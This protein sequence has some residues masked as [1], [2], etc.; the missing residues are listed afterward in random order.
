MALAG[1]QDR[2][3]RIADRVD[4]RVGNKAKGLARTAGALAAAD[5]DLEIARAVGVTGAHKARVDADERA[6]AAGGRLAG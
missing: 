1:Q 4:F 3:A 5:G 6:V 2:P